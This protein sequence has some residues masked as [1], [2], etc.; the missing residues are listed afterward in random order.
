[1]T[2]E[3]KIPFN[4][5]GEKQQAAVAIIKHLR[6]NGFQA[7]MA[8]GSVRDMLL[9][10]DDTGDIDIATSARP[11][12][13]QRLFSNVVPVGEHFGV[14]IVVECGIA[15]EVATFRAD[16]GGA[17]GR[18]PESVVFTD[19]RNDALRRDFTINGMFYDP[20]TEQ[21]LDFVGGREDLSKGVIRAIGEPSQRFAEDYLR[22]LRAIRFSAR[23]SFPIEQTTWDAITVYHE[24]LKKI[25]AERV[26]A[27]LDR[28]MSGP[29]PDQ[30]LV[31][32]KDSGLLKETLPEVAALIGVAQPP[33]FHPEGDVFE[34]TVKA[35]SFLTNQSRVLGWSALLHDIGK[36]P[37][38]Q[39]RDRIRFNN[40][41][42]VGA[43]MASKALRRLKAPRALI[44]QVYACIDNH[45]NFMNVQKMKLSTLKR[46]LAR[47]TLQDE[48]ELHRVDCLA[49]HGDLANYSFLKEQL[50]YH[51]E[52]RIA[53]PAY[54]R[55]KDLVHLG[56]KPGP[57]FGVIL[58][59][60]YDLQL[61]EKLKSSEEAIQWV[62]A[63]HPP[64][65][66]Q[67]G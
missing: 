67:K 35:L 27:E 33:E 62:R 56:Y 19:A 54:L 32:L 36:P 59:E 25:S 13:I 26:F 58:K 50:A 31:L 11:N 24:G 21:L 64:E 63:N 7:L 48:L 20:V 8:G 15:F 37:T 40:H 49:S 43:A 42:R 4:P 61:E 12:E 17:D 28:M 41:H 14:M 38:F 55:G 29:N 30:A 34:H 44:D 6:A 2:P 1:M 3:Q 57:R 53:P 22:L 45:M 23:F 39:V 65:E 52:E 5:H 9:G 18:H 10:H 16:I 60:A 51:G 46:F 47:P 66:S